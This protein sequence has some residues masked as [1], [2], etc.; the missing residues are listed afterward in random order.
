M[1]TTNRRCQEW[2]ME[3][4]RR[5]RDLNYISPEAVELAQAE[6]DPPTHGIG[7]RPVRQAETDPTGVSN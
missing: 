4:L 1:V 2:T 5:L 3:Y 6:R 7:L